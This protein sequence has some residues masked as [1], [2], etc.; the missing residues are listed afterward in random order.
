MRG[1]EISKNYERIQD[2]SKELFKIYPNEIKFLYRYGMFLSQIVNNEYDAV[3]YLEQ[4][5]H[6]F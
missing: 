4:A 6:I 2:V 1:A 3:N 5:Y